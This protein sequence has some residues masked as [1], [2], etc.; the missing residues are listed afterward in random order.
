MNMFARRCEVK[1]N[2][3]ENLKIGI[4]GRCGTSVD[5]QM[6]TE[7][8]KI[9]LYY[10]RLAEI[11][12]TSRPPTLAPHSPSVFISSNKRKERIKKNCVHTSDILK[13]LIRHRLKHLHLVQLTSSLGILNYI[14]WV[15]FSSFLNALILRSN[16]RISEEKRIEKYLVRR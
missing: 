1:Q 2:R 14:K 8:V 13:G 4:N 11:P 10:T 12:P 9:V 5:V 3:K 15:Y 16:F 6:R 7:T